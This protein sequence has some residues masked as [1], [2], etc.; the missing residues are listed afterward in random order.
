MVDARTAP[1]SAPP[2]VARLEAARAELAGE[3]TRLLYARHPEWEGRW[4]PSG[5]EAARRDMEHHVDFLRAALAAGEPAIFADYALWLW[6]VLE[7]RRVPRAV[8]AESFEV[9]CALLEKLLAEDESTSACAVV[10]SGIEALRAPAPTRPSWPP[11][12]RDGAELAEALLAGDRRRAEDLLV[13]QVRSGRALADVGDTVVQPAMHEV[14]RLWQENRITV[15]Q[16]HLAANVVQTVFARA[17][18]ASEFEPARRGRALFACVEGNRHDLG[19]RI[20]ADSFEH[21]GWHVRYLG[22]DVPTRDL[23]ALARGGGLDVVG[24]SLSLPTHVPAAQAAVAALRASLGAACPQILVGGI[25]TNQV[26]GL[27]RALGADAWYP[28]ATDALEQAAR[29]P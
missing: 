12:P 23:V 22:A 8:L 26:A 5:R 15:A 21:A 24:L 29:A 27:W 7:A 28:G 16:E 13:G 2:L 9:L 10:R 18:A 3:G 1:A 14:G 20:V 6:N 19:L 11:L 17:A 25:A 4:G